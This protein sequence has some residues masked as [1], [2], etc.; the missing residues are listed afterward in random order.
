ME[1]WAE[2]TCSLFPSTLLIFLILDSTF[3]ILDFP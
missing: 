2:A 3:L 1:L